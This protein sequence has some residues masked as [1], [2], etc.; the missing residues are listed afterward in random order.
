MV[1]MWIPNATLN[2]AACKNN[3]G[4][5]Y[6]PWQNERWD[7]DSGALYN[8]MVRP[9]LRMTIKAVLWYQGMETSCALL[10]TS[11][12]VLVGLY[13]QMA[14]AARFACAI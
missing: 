2:N 11:A 4:G 1:E 13:M 8:G 14:H 5:A 10:V 3:S 7:I 6:E 12:R 9:F